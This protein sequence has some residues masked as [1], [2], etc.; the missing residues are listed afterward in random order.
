M[1]HSTTA[2][3]SVAY[4]P[5]RLRAP[6]A[7]PPDAC[8]LRASVIA[9]RPSMAACPSSMFDIVCS[10]RIVACHS[11]RDGAPPRVDP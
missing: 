9:A 2:A 11:S 3:M 4:S 6:D 5:R 1:P 10:P 7:P 8:R